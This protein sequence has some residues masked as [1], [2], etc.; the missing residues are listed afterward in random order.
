MKVVIAVASFSHQISGV[1]RHAINLAR[2]LLTRAAISAVHLI[3]SPWQES[4]IRDAMPD[5]D[6][7]FHLH[8][9]VIGSGTI[10]RNFWYYRELPQVAAKLGADIVHL[11]YPSPLQRGAFSCPTVVTLHDLY[12]YDIPENFG[13]PKVWVNRLI[14]KQCLGAAGAIACVSESTRTR[15]EQLFPHHVARKASVI[16]NCVEPPPKPERALG[17][18]TTQTPITEIGAAPFLL[19][20]AQHR[21]NKNIPLLLRVFHRLHYLGRISS[22]MRLV[23]LGIPGPETKAIL[24]FVADAGISDRVILL[25]GISEADLQW[26]YCNCEL[27]VAPSSVEGFGLPVAEALMAG[28][29]VICSDIPVFREVGGDRCRYVPLDSHAEEAFADA[30]CSSLVGPRGT[31]ALLPQLSRKTIAAQY[32]QLYQS[33]NLQTSKARPDAIP[34]ID[35]KEGRSVL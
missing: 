25:S 11:G 8:S 20:V 16:C 3:A 26:C 31:P 7:R 4:L 24:S 12:P 29:R 1:Q 30:I 22:D 10:A 14:L 15:L 21:R 19:S 9:A 18:S 27:L 23:I 2:C 34:A 35:I 17:V 6:A 5:A 28:C 32:L 13:F 33:L